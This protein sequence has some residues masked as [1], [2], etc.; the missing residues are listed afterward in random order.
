MASLD[1]SISLVAWWGAILSTFL[2]AIKVREIWRDRFRVDISHSFAGL[3]YI[4]NKVL[5]R[6]LGVR[7]FILADWALLYCSGRW[8]CRRLE[9]LAST[10]SDNTDSKVDPGSTYTLHFVD[11]NY[12]N[13]GGSA[14]NGRRIYIRLNVAGRQPKYRKV[15]SP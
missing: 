13:W 9:P 4:G 10:E 12:F 14:L 7:P 1:P 5:I 15:Y 6:N 8:P 2:A 3:S 11:E